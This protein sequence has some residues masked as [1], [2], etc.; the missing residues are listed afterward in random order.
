MIND[1]VDEEADQK[2]ES[3]RDLDRLIDL[4]QTDLTYKERQSKPARFD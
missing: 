3:I 4:S 2:N 1:P